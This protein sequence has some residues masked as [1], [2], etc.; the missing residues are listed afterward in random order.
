M[1][2]LTGSLRQI[3]NHHPVK[4]ALENTLS[5][6]GSAGAENI[7]PSAPRPGV[8]RGDRLC[9]GF[10][11]RWIRSA[12]G[13]PRLHERITPVLGHAAIRD[14]RRKWFDHCT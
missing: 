4:K 11:S 10:G 9:A 12:G 7:A 2:R 14:I 1:C 5:S 6:S 8:S 13:N 3:S